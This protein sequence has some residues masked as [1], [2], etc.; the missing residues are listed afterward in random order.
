MV[1]LKSRIAVTVA[2]GYD[3]ND[4]NISFVFPTKIFV[5]QCKFKQIKV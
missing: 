4:E 5:A 1:F 2:F 3:N